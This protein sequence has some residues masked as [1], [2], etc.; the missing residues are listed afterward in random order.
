MKELTTV[1]LFGEIPY[2][3]RK[4]SEEGKRMNELT[5]EKLMTTREVAEG[6]G[7]A[8]NTIR[9]NAKKC[10]PN[11]V[12]ENG[13]TT[14]WTKAEVTV[15]ID[16]MKSN[17]NRS[18]L[19]SCQT[20][21]QV[22]TDLTP[23]LK[24]KQA[25]Q[26][27]Q[28]AYEEELQIIKAKAQELETKNNLLMFTNKTYTMTEIAKELG[29]TSAMELNRILAE[30]KIQYKSNGTWVSYANYADKGY[31]ETKQDIINGITVYNRHVTQKG[32]LFILSLFA[33]T[34]YE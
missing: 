21:R 5:N 24:I 18:D 33:N 19:P 3:Y 28:E 31:F 13:K 4:H 9:E 7:C 10:L 1:A 25:M 29:L 17:N 2:N 14:Y 12:F 30:K 26:M 32:R 8:I 16:F 6:I 27:M 15:L 34:K 20:V 11:K 22:T 23:A